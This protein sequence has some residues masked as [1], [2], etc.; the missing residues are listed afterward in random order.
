MYRLKVQ[1]PNLFKSVYIH[2][3]TTEN[4]MEDILLIFHNWKTNKLEYKPSFIFY[5]LYDNPVNQMLKRTLYKD[6]SSVAINLSYE[7]IWKTKI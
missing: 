4:Y 3:E 2:E 6:I 7:R 1:N 5:V